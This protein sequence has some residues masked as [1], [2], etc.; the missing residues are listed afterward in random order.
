MT[1][2]KLCWANVSSGN[3][4]ASKGSEKVAGL[5]CETPKIGSAAITSA[6][7]AAVGV[8]HG[9]PTFCF[10][11]IARLPPSNICFDWLETSEIESGIG[12]GEDSNDNESAVWIG[13]AKPTGTGP[14]KAF[15]IAVLLTLP[16]HSGLCSTACTIFGACC[17]R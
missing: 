11:S 14:A 1:N 16:K 8:L 5:T 3:E 9:E 6:K 15:G 10:R 12:T 17:G 7:E 2:H 4:G 13:V